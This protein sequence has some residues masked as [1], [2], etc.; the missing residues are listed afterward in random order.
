MKLRKQKDKIKRNK[1]ER[2]MKKKKRGV[3]LEKK[4]KRESFNA[5]INDESVLT[6]PVFFSIVG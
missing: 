3:E 4:K 2:E 6:F 1:K 5:H